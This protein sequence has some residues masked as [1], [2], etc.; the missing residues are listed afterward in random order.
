MIGKSAFVAATASVWGLLTGLNAAVSIKQMTWQVLGARKGRPDSM[1][2]TTNPSPSFARSPVRRAQGA[3]AMR[4][5]V[6]T[7]CV[8]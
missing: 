1:E 5:K 2:P 4:L 8:P 6:A 3:L 7:Q